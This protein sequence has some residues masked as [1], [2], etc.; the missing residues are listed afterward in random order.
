M[1]LTFSQARKR[2]EERFVNICE[3]LSAWCMLATF[4]L[5]VFLLLHNMGIV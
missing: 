1:K 2:R 3:T 5:T 4:A